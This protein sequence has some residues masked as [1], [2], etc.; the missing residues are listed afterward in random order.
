MQLIM[1][2]NFEGLNLL[3]IKKEQIQRGKINCLFQ[4]MVSMT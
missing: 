1:L 4:E 3:T 2:C